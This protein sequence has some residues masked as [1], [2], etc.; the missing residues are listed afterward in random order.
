M[1]RF[2]I[3]ALVAGL[4]TLGLGAA[5]T[6]K[7]KPKE[8]PKPATVPFEMLKSGHMAV[9]VKVNGKGPYR[10]IFDT[11]AP[12]SLVNNALAKESGLLKGMPKNPFPIFGNIGEATIKTLEVGTQKAENIPAVVMDHPTV[13]ALARILDTKLYGIV[14]FGFFAQFKVTLDYQKKTMTLE[15]SGYK[16][17]NVMGAMQSLLLSG[18][19]KEVLG[20]KGQWGLVCGKEVGDNDDGVDIKEVLEGSP[21][22]S[23]G[24]KRGDRLLTLDGRWTDSVKDVFAAAGQVKA[25]TAVVVKIKRGKEEKELKVTPKKGF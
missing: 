9:M 23:A 8:K 20:A 2:L 11:G 12:I 15:P 14:G 5:D 19:K 10:L 13:D 21:A 1:K 4:V 18:S 3:P 17:K 7:D 24:L 16:P 6:P 22:A 25:G